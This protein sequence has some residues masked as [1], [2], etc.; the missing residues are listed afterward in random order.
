MGPCTLPRE[1]PQITAEGHAGP[2]VFS[3][4]SKPN[5]GFTQRSA[6]A[7]DSHHFSSLVHTFLTRLWPL[8]PMSVSDEL[9]CE[10]SACF[11]CILTLHSNLTCRIPSLCADPSS[12]SSSPLPF[13][14]VLILQERTAV[15]RKPPPSRDDHPTQARSVA[16]PFATPYM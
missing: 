11:S 5:A 1:K 2:W 13:V 8:V 6:E 16:E 12:R 7:R 10:V 14:M 15:L 4:V 9:C 3:L